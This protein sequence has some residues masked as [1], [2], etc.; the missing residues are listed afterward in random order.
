MKIEL[1]KQ[2]FVDEYGSSETS[3]KYK[4]IKWCCEKIEH[5]PLINIGIDE[6]YG[7]DESNCSCNGDC[8]DCDIDCDDT[9]DEN[10]MPSVTLKYTT[11]ITSY[12]DTWT[13]CNYYRI[14]YCPFCGEPIEVSIVKEE[15]VSDI[16]Q[17]L[18]KEKDEVWNEIEKTDSIKKQNE[19]HKISQILSRQIHYFDSLAEYNPSIKEIIAANEV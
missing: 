2:T 10:R 7:Y 5:N 1:I 6:N 16:Y 14:D 17:K 11:T 9:N 4:P 15:D 3:F 13:E 8:E 19:L 12:E 18:N